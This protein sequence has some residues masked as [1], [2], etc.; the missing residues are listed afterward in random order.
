MRDGGLRVRT[1]TPRA[2]H[3]AFSLVLIT[4]I[5]MGCAE[6]EAHRGKLIGALVGAGAGAA[7]GGAAKGPRGALIGAMIGFGLGLAAGAYVDRQTGNRQA[8]VEQL[9]QSEIPMLPDLPV[10]VHIKSYRVDPPRARP[11]DRVIVHADYLIFARENAD[12]LIDLEEW[13]LVRQVRQDGSDVRQ[14]AYRK[15]RLGQGVHYSQFKF[16]IPSD[17]PSG[18]YV[19]VTVVRTVNEQQMMQTEAALEVCTS[20]VTSATC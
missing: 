6:L 19:I 13:R 17:A 12:E 18:S 2:I 10:I 8:A 9:R 3:R 15:I 7:V 16:E 11:G 20:P 1:S 4:T 14:P 5:L